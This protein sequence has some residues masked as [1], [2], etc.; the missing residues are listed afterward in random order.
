MNELILQHGSTAQWG[1]YQVSVREERSHTRR[2]TEEGGGG[3][4]GG[5]S[6]RKY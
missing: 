4:R 2:T 5:V 1:F 3:A 6:G